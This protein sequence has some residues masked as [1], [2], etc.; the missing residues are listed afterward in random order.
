MNQRPKVL[1]YEPMH[2]KGIDY[3]KM[4]ADVLYASSWDE[5]ILCQEVKDISGII[6]RANGKVT[7][8]IMDSAPKLKVIGRHGAGVDNI[9]LEAAK[10]RGIT[11]VNT[12]HAPAEAVAEHVIGVMVVLSKRILESDRALRA[13]QWDVRYHFQAFEM[14]GKTLGIVGMGRI[15]S[16][17]AEMAKALGME[18]L[19]YDVVVNPQVEGKYDAKKIE[20]EELLKLS[21]YITLHVPATPETKYLINAERL[22]L[23][24]PTAILVNAARG[25][26]VDTM[27]LYD[28]LKSGKLFGAAIDVF[29]KEPAP[30]DHPLFSLP[31]VVVTPHMAGHSDDALIAMSMV[32]KDIIRVIQ[33]Q[34]PEYPVK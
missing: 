21:D 7:T 5:D 27:A 32:A 23:M 28:A 26:V 22:K 31:N 19:Y 24:K 16:R 17:V 13:G 1:L 34:P 14:K 15:G 25:S 10:K 6:I 3:L 20:L 9:D 29:E 11:V 33:G 2:Q 18:I 4:Y 8:K 30:A 12:P